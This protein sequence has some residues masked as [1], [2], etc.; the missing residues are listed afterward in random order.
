MIKTKKKTKE[1]KENEENKENKEAKDKA[2]YDMIMKTPCG[3][4]GLYPITLPCTS[5][6]NHLFC[7]YCLEA[8]LMNEGY[9][10]CP[11]C[12]QLIRRCT[13]VIPLP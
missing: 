8:S 12:Y 6:C 5:N 13:R 2:F 3:I 9:I 4:C 1:N 10:Q 11:L 7:Y